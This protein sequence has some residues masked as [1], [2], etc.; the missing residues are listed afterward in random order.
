[1]K[2]YSKNREIWVSGH[3]PLLDFHTGLLAKVYVVTVEKRGRFILQDFDTLEEKGAIGIAIPTKEGSKK[4]LKMVELEKKQRKNL[5]SVG[6]IKVAQYQSYL[7]PWLR[8]LAE[9]NISKE[10]L[11]DVSVRVEELTSVIAPGKEFKNT[12]DLAINVYNFVFPKIGL[13]EVKFE[14]ASRLLWTEWYESLLE[15]VE[16]YNFNNFWIQE[17]GIRLRPSS[18]KEVMVALDQ[19]KLLP[20][21]APLAFCVRRS[22]FSLV[23]GLGQEKYEKADVYISRLLKVTRSEVATS[24]QGLP[25]EWKKLAGLDNFRPS[26]LLLWLLGGNFNPVNIIRYAY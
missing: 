9:R 6:P 22:N 14:L 8:S 3:Q 24:R 13:P 5:F 2:H 20:K 17:N 18:K 25:P 23:N 26:A 16:L 21:A 1:M 12:T 10:I 4:N 7:L 15:A 11:R 19:R